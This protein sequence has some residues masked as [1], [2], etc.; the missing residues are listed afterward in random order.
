MSCPHTLNALFNATARGL[1][2]VR[3]SRRFDRTKPTKRMWG[4]VRGYWSG[5]IDA[6]FEYLDDSGGFDTIQRHT[7]LAAVSGAIEKS[8]SDADRAMLAEL[9]SQFGYFDDVQARAEVI[10]AATSFPTFEEAA[11]FALAQLGITAADFALRNEAVK[12]VLLSRIDAAVFA[13]RHHIDRAMDT[14]VTQFHE[15]GRNPHDPRFIRELRKDLGVETD[16][17]AQRFA[18]TETGISSQVAQ[19]ET[20]RRSGVETKVW[21]VLGR[22]TRPSHAA[23]A[24]VEIGIDEQF[25]VGGYPADRPCDPSLSPG[26]LINCQCWLTPGVDDD[27]EVDPGNVWEGE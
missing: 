3:R 7:Q 19:A 24:G 8:L 2:K 21:N 13:T 1:R 18:V 11:K 26:E 25:D 4:E 27:F 22:N 15:L 17:E 20:Y 12:E 14:I 9:L 23:L 6:L 5:G 10:I 16:W